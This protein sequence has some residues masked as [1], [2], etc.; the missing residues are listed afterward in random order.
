MPR[1]ISSSTAWPLDPLGG[2]PHK[3]V[4]QLP[5]QQLSEDALATRQPHQ[6]DTAVKLRTTVRWTRIKPGA[7][8]KQAGWRSAS[9]SGR[10]A[11]AAGM[12]CGQ[13]RRAPAVEQ[14][15]RTGPGL[16]DRRLT[17]DAGGGGWVMGWH[18]IPF[19]FPIE[20]SEG[21]RLAMALYSTAILLVIFAVLCRLADGRRYRGDGPPLRRR[22]PAVPARDQDGS[23]MLTVRERQLWGDLVAR[24]DTLRHRRGR[25]PTERGGAA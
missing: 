18:G 13:D 4:L 6:L 7:F 16:A 24:Y 17:K 9:V 14:T 10:S 3:Q 2:Q 25:D 15:R 19:H 1:L 23:G 21:A 12:A 8:G 20:V 22:F 11:S 5:G